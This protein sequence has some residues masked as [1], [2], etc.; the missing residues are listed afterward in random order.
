MIASLMDF[1][2]YQAEATRFR[3][4]RKGLDPDEVKRFQARASRSLR[5][6]ERELAEAAV[7]IAQ[8]ERAIAGGEPVGADPFASPGETPVPVSAAEPRSTEAAQAEAAAI[9]ERALAE[10]A[11]IADRAEQADQEAAVVLEDATARAAE[12]IAA[13]ELEATELATRT[14]ATAENRAATLG[15]HAA[16]RSLEERMVSTSA[17]RAREASREELARAG[18]AVA[19]C[20]IADARAEAEA[21]LEAAALQAS[22]AEDEAGRRVAMAN[23]VAA[24]EARALEQ[25]LD[26]LRSVIRETESRFR[27][28]A[29]AS[30]GDPTGA[31]PAVDS[32]VIELEGPDVVIDLTADP[33]LPGDALHDRRAAKML[34]PDELPDVAVAGGDAAAPPPIT[35]RD[36]DDLRRRPGFYQRRLAGLR[37]RIDRY[38]D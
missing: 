6:Y 35:S 17:R 30:L 25:R 26:G 13:A 23:A 14:V 16:A 21:V 5:A 9:L 3:P 15:A 1:T 28:L 33:E 19:G 29:E 11:S 38:E 4:A 7:R 27:A 8:L 34:P 31:D 24:D 22:A 10:H 32:V 2:S 37:E 20:V 12:L 36:P 18:R